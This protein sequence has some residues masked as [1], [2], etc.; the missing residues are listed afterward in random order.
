MLLQKSHVPAALRSTLRLVLRALV[1]VAEP[2]EILS[3]HV[4][5]EDVDLMLSDAHLLVLPQS[6]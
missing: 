3:R 6:I 2:T 4:E 1:E 5:K